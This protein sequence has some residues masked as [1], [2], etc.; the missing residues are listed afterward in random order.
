MNRGVLGKA[1]I[2]GNMVQS[3]GAGL[4][5]IGQVKGGRPVVLSG[6]PDAIIHLIPSHLDTREVIHP[7][8]I[9]NRCYLT[10][11]LQ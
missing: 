1:A 5:E 8:V 6:L 10:W 11:K 3:S 9:T 2:P 7:L 4:F